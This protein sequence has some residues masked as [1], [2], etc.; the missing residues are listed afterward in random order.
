MLAI[1]RRMSLST[2]CLLAM[3]SVGASLAQD[4]SYP[5][6]EIRIIVPAAPGSPPDIISRIVATE[7]SASEDWRLVIENRSGA[8]Q[9]HDPVLLHHF[10][11]RT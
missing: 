10:G 3:S 7:L 9:R 6:R 11:A 4:Q 2:A 1:S 5:I 8:P